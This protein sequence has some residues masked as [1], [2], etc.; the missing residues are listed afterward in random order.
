MHNSNNTI[1]HFLCQN[2]RVWYMIVEVEDPN[3]YCSIEDNDQQ[4]LSQMFIIPF[5]KLFIIKI[6]WISIGIKQET[7]EQNILVCR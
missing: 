6:E 1:L 3:C 2:K 5:L 4:S 7:N